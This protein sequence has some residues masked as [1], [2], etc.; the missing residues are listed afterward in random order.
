MGAYRSEENGAAV[1]ASGLL[2]TATGEV[3]FSGPEELS[4]LI[5]QDPRFA[6]CATE[7]LLTYAVG[8]RFD[9]AD[10]KAYTTALTDLAVSAG[11]PNW[12]AFIEQVARSDAFLTGRGEAQ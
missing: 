3:A 1:N 4:P 9:L 6:R 8:R 7:K 12:R 11:T 5:A 10:A 2:P